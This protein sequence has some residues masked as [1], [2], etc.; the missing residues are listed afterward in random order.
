MRSRALFIGAA[1][2]LIF[3]FPPSASGQ[4][5]FG[6]VARQG[7]VAVVGAYEPQVE[8]FSGAVDWN[9]PGPWSFRVEGGS[10]GAYISDA[11]LETHQGWTKIGTVVEEDQEYPIV[12][13][14]TGENVFGA[15][16]LV[17]LVV[18]GWSFCA[19][20]GLQGLS[21]E[22]SFTQR[23]TFLDAFGPQWATGT[24]DY[25]GARAPLTVGAGFED[26]TFGEAN[27]VPFATFTYWVDRVT[28]DR[29]VGS[30]RYEGWFGR[31]GATL[32][33]DRFSLG[34]SF[35]TEDDLRDQSILASLGFAF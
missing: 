11:E 31:V 34:L 29:A 21:G 32:R 6:R 27:L 4:A 3:S 28:F 18:S 19:A 7:E 17:E 20:G 25:S 12:T 13:R 22:A 15:E 5:C 33:Y 24:Q 30:F 26:L 35:R 16:A 23:V 1:T 10:V 9:V 14:R 8:G 2:F